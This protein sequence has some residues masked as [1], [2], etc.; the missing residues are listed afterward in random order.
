LI[1]EWR[2][3]G[4]GFPLQ[5]IER[6]T[7]ENSILRSFAFSD[8]SDRLLGTR[9]LPSLPTQSANAAAVNNR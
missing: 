4:V 7:D 8:Y 3:S 6:P 9:I 1:P 2:P 5:L